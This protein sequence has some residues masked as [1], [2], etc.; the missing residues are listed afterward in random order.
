MVNTGFVAL[1]YCT[2]RLFE[3]TSRVFQF[4]TSTTLAHNFLDHTKPPLGW[5]D[6]FGTAEG[7]CLL[8]KQYNTLPKGNYTFSLINWSSFHTLWGSILNSIQLDNLHWGDLISPSIYAI[9]TIYL[10]SFSQ[11]TM[12][13]QIKCIRIGRRYTD[14][15]GF[16]AF[17]LS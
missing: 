17:L 16:L 3:A 12:T 14:W 2:V 10:R 1:R 11:Q 15:P 5:F 7:I 9:I 8:I 13:V 6:F 4:S